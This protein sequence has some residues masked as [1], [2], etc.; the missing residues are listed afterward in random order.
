MRRLALR[1]GP[2]GDFYR[3]YDAIEAARSFERSGEAASTWTRVNSCTET[4]LAAK[5][6]INHPELYS[7]KFAV[8]AF[9]K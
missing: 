1:K 2:D 9:V 6:H 7:P 5:A 8:P 4:R 3:A